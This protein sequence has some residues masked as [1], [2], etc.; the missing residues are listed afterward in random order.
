[1]PATASASASAPP[2]A[3][4]AQTVGFGTAGPAP[5]VRPV[6][7]PGSHLLG[8][9]ARADALADVPEDVTHLA[10]G[11]PVTVIDLKE[12]DA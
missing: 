7:G 12:R 8:A 11:T 1:M 3:D 9:L 5:A 6:G 2:A 4:L 10:A